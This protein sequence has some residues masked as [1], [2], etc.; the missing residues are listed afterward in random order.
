VLASS[1]QEVD[2]SRVQEEYDALLENEAKEEGEVVRFDSVVGSATEELEAKFS[3]AR[4]YARRL[5]T[6]I[7]SSPSGHTFINGKYYSLN[8]VSSTTLDINVKTYEG[9]IELLEFTAVRDRTGTPVFPREGEFTAQ[10]LL[11]WP[12]F[13]TDI[14]L[15]SIQVRLLMMMLMTSRTTFLTCP[16]R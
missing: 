3:K 4:A 16:R 10:L 2:W 13:L 6:T 15:R 9:G 14:S 12:L 5:G 1:K 11:P 8:N 7:A